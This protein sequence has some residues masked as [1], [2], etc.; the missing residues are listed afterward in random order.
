VISQ[1]KSLLLPMNTIKEI[2]EKSS[3]ED[4]ENSNKIN[5]NINNQSKENND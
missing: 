4:I 5:R 2:Q 3:S 1:G